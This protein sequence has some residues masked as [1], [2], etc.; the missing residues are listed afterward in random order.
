MSENDTA[1]KAENTESSVRILSDYE[2]RVLAVALDAKNGTGWCD[3]GFN[4]SMRKLDLPTKPDTTSNSNQITVT[5]PTAGS[6][7]YRLSSGSVTTEAEALAA[8]ANMVASDNRSV[9]GQNG[10]RYGTRGPVEF[11][12]TKATFTGLPDGTDSRTDEQKQWD[13]AMEQVKAF[14]AGATVDTED[15]SDDDGDDY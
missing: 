7:T 8:I 2:V 1:V 13:S 10:L 14:R 12:T 3:E 4:Q 15:E 11:D 6:V 5:V 9:S